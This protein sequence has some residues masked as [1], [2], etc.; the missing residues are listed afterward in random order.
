MWRS[1][2][3]SG[4][5]KNV[6]QTVFFGRPL[7]LRN[8]IM[9]IEDSV[10]R[11]NGGHCRRTMTFSN[12]NRQQ[13]SKLLRSFVR[14]RSVGRL[15]AIFVLQLTRT[16]VH[17]SL[18]RKYFLLSLSLYLL[19]SVRLSLSLS[20]SLSPSVHSMVHVYRRHR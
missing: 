12:H 20:F 8:A 15:G 5:K 4:S 7:P 10:A 14:K 13:L 11:F 18:G 17:I 3:Y 19:P 16:T 1:V 6:L 9:I 2:V